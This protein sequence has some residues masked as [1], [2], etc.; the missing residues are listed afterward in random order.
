M[1]R[2]VPDEHVSTRARDA[3]SADRV[4]VEAIGESFEQSFDGGELA[5]HL[6]V[7]RG[8]RAAS[9]DLVGAVL[10][11]ATRCPEE[12]AVGDDGFAQFLLESDGFGSG[13]F[14]ACTVDGDQ[15]A[16]AR[17]VSRYRRLTR[18]EPD[19]ESEYSVPYTLL[20][21]PGSKRYRVPRTGVAMDSREHSILRPVRRTV[22]CS[23][24]RCGDCRVRLDVRLDGG[25]VHL[26]FGT[27]RFL[28]DRRESIVGFAFRRT[29]YTTEATSDCLELT[30]EPGE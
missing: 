10:A 2:E 18:E 21:E 27:L 26:L 17:C 4:G 19:P 23:I 1:F 24:S 9:S 20:S 11:V 5:E 12:L 6:R 28:T 16:F 3:G 8:V 29:E 22:G 7:P 14:D 15:N 25:H 30:F 13:Q